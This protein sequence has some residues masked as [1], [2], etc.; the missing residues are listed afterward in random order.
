MPTGTSPSLQKVISVSMASRYQGQTAADSLQGRTGH[1]GGGHKHEAAL[2]HR[3]HRRVQELRW[4][5]VRVQVDRLVAVRV[6]QA[7]CM[8]NEPTLHACHGPRELQK[9]MPRCPWHACVACGRMP[10]QQEGCVC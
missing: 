1:V 7:R 10:A 9:E 5:A 4:G 6:L 2:R 8:P 3:L